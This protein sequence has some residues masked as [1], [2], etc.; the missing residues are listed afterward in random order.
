MSDSD[1][2]EYS[3]DAYDPEIEWNTK[4]IIRDENG[5]VLYDPTTGYV[6]PSYE[7]EENNE[8]IQQIEPERIELDHN[9]IEIEQ[10]EDDLEE[11]ENSD[12]GA[13]NYEDITGEV[14]IP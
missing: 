2:D 13:E 3:G 7:N 6:S 10:T 1:A 4:I 8:Q 14:V 12:E 11:L 9:S 5:L